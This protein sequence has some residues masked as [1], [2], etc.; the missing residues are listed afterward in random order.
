MDLKLDEALSR[1]ILSASG[2]RAIF[3]EDG[4]EES[5]APGISDSHR[6]I[7][8]AAAKVFSDY[9]YDDWYP[10]SRLLGAWREPP[11]IIAG[12]DT[13]PTGEAIADAILRSLLAAREG[14]AAQVMYAGITAI[15][16]FKALARAVPATGFIYISA[17]HNPAGH[18]GLKFGLGDGGVLPPDE[19]QKLVSAFRSFMASPLCVIKAEASAGAKVEDLA[20]IYASEKKCKELAAAVYNK[21]TG[22]V[23]SGL[24][25]IKDKPKREEFFSILRR[26]LE[27]R[28]LG[29]AADFNGS[30]RAVSIDREF[31]T[32]LGVT[33]RALNETPGEITH[34]IVPEGESLE[35]CRA[36]LDELHR[37]D[38]SFVLGYTCDCDGDRGN[39]VFFD[40]RE[41]RARILEAQEVFA[42]ACVAELSFLVSTGELKFDE[43]GNAVTKAAIAVND[44]TSIRIERIARAFGVDVFRA[45]VGE[46]NVVSLARRL[47]EQGYL[48]RILG[49]G[50]NGG[51]IIHPSSVRDPINTVSAILKLLAIRGGKSEDNRGLFEIWC[52]RSNQAEIYRNDFTLSD[53]IAALP[54]FATTGAATN[55]A[56]LWIKTVDHGI[57]KERYQKI[58]LRD[59]E[60]KRRE[61]L[62]KYGISGWEAIAYNGMNENHSI[63]SFSEAGRGGLKIEFTGTSKF[64]G[65]DGEKTAFIWMRG[66][67]TEPVFRIMADAECTEAE[68]ELIEWQRQ[69]VLEADAA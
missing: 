50:S 13:R 44:P 16:E 32:S 38:K 29:I 45:E 53:I 42:L 3:A 68:R 46:A 47:R 27:E 61:L 64:N 69:M 28:P 25:W 52:G 5:P 15:P 11:I 37:E 14:A 7:A 57:L 1:M 58:F 67:G 51:T 10:R 48:V 17:S 6:V 54:A 56:M 62:E 31:F 49:E 23:I 9:I 30:A 4:D 18:N 33:F 55:D 36:F 59:W 65:K 34:R 8:A 26:G 22:E 63:G 41:N 35:P 20:A 43:A 24:V 66:S 19:S 12:R 39:L 2:W 60:K 21:Y 40:E